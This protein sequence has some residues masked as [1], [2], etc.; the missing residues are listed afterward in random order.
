M[1]NA[2]LKKSLFPMMKS[3]TFTCKFMMCPHSSNKGLHGRSTPFAF[4]INQL[5]KHFCF[6]HPQFRMN[7]A[8]LCQGLPVRSILAKKDIPRLC[9]VKIKIVLAQPISREDRNCRWRSI[10]ICSK[11]WRWLRRFS[12]KSKF[13]FTTSDR[14][15]TLFAK[16]V[17]RHAKK[18]NV[19]RV[20]PDAFP[21][22]AYTLLSNVNIK[23]ILFCRSISIMILVV[24][25]RTCTWICGEQIR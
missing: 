22:G 15:T 6:S 17:T 21:I 1:E 12:V 18:H 2:K 3:N 5:D 19:P 11:V 14:E 20:V 23:S 13:S 8:S 25:V 24:A 10:Q 9:C 4:S 7:P 16:R